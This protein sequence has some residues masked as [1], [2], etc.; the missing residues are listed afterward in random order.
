MSCHSANKSEDAV[1]LMV[2]E[3]ES[4]LDETTRNNTSKK[5]YDHRRD[6]YDSEDRR[7]FRR[8][9][10]RRIIE[11][12]Q[13]DYYRWDNRRTPPSRSTNYRQESNYSLRNNQ[14]RREENMRFNE[15][16]YE[17]TRNVSRKTMPSRRMQSNEGSWS[18]SK[19]IQK[20]N[21]KINFSATR[22]RKIETQ[23]E[24]GIFPTTSNM[25][26][27]NSG[28]QAT[29]PAKRARTPTSEGAVPTANKKQKENGTVQETKPKKV[30]TQSG[31]NVLHT[32][33]EERRENSKV[34]IR[35]ME[36]SKEVENESP[37]K[38]KKDTS[39]V[40]KVAKEKSNNREDLGKFVKNFKETHLTYDRKNVKEIVK[41]KEVIRKKDSREV[42]IIEDEEDLSDVTHEEKETLQEKELIELLQ[43]NSKRLRKLCNHFRILA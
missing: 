16:R 21:M 23:S 11:R 28:K 29:M 7:Y 36:I 10:N 8:T 6:H 12:D 4:L 3:T 13:K 18:T 39:S 14:P 43:K 2:S 31:E 41:Q 25:R 30:R 32:T 9:N 35:E 27:G 42:I 22:S 15:S 1:S 20:S 37:A 34:Q 17:P 40:M 5:T 38:L 24:D 26:K 19:N 33:E